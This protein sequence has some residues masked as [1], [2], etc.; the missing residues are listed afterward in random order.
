MAPRITPDAA[1]TTG[2]FPAWPVIPGVALLDAVWR[3]LLADGFAAGV[4]RAVRGV[5]FLRPVG[6]GRELVL[7]ASGVGEGVRFLLAEGAEVVARGW[8]LG[9]PHPTMEW[10]ADAPDDGARRIADELLPHRPPMRLVEAVVDWSDSAARCRGRVGDGCPLGDGRIA[11]AW[12]LIEV[13]AQA[14]AVHAGLRAG[15]VG[16][17]PPGAIVGLPVVELECG[18][19]PC[20]RSLLA[21]VEIIRAMP[22]AMVYRA[23]VSGGG[24]RLISGE[25][26][27]VPELPASP[28]IR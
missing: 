27:V 1:T 11:P 2:H 16:P 7:S 28:P 18:A 8:L 10:G 22:P 20:G 12:V 9:G 14:A 6:P 17:R 21:E 5:R 25:I 19:V 13:A 24:A 4:P 26:T 23:V 3:R 15:D